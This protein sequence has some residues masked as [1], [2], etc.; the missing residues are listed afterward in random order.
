MGA[1]NEKFF[2]F[3]E[4]EVGKLYKVHGISLFKGQHDNLVQSY[5]KVKIDGGYVVFL[6]RHFP[7]LRT[8][9]HSTELYMLYKSK[10]LSIGGIECAFEFY[11]DEDNSSDHVTQQ[12]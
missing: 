9:L 7:D 2:K 11:I 6:E 10:Q 1:A 8:H 5:I 3:D 12:N 4:L